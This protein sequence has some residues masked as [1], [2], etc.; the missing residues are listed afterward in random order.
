MRKAHLRRVIEQTQLKESVPCLDITAEEFAAL[1]E[2]GQRGLVEAGPDAE[3][4]L[5]DVTELLAA[6][7]AAANE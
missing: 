7:R 1:I 5:L 2:A 6:R 4:H 3:F